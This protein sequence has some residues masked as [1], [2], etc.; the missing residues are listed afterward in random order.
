MIFISNIQLMLS[1]SI[2]SISGLKLSNESIF[3]LNII[4][5]GEYLILNQIAFI[6]VKASQANMFML[7]LSVL[8]PLYVGIAMSNHDAPVFDL[9]QNSLL[10]IEA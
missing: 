1:T 8:Y 5:L 4:S 2:S 6:L 3:C 7:Q 9:F 10:V